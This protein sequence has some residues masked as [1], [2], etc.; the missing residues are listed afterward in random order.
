[1]TTMPG[2]RSRTAAPPRRRGLG[3]AALVLGLIALPLAFLCGIGLLPGLAGLAIGIIAVMRDQGRTQA[4]IGIVTSALALLIAGGVAFWLI[5]KAAKCGDR[6]HYP[7]DTA[8]RA[9]IEREFP[10]VDRNPG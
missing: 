8:R 2:Y 3:L 10:M 9:C 6:A 7:D 1:M 5:S 4:I